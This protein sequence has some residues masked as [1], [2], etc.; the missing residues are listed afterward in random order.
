MTVKGLSI[1]YGRPENPLRAVRDV[2]FS[3]KPGEAYGLIGES[4]SGKTTVAFSVMNYRNG[5]NVTG[6]TVEFQHRN[7]FDLSREDLR[8]LRGNRIA[9][10]YQDPM[11]SLNPGLKIG[12]QIAEILREHTQMSAD[13][14]RQRSVALLR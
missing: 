9:M 8:Q 1:A 10:V 6:G 11:D 12:E 3:I 5:G 4:G 2:S 7:I 14:V 13:E